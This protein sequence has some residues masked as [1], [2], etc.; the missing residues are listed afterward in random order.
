MS[1]SGWGPGGTTGPSVL[2]VPFHGGVGHP[3][4]GP[5][6]TGWIPRLA[7][8]GLRSPLV[9]PRGARATARGV[10]VVVHSCGETKVSIKTNSEFLIVTPCS[11]TIPKLEH[12]GLLNPKL[13][14]K[15]E[16]KWGSHRGPSISLVKRQYN[17]PVV[18]PFYCTRLNLGISKV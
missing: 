4:G 6:S 10:L 13:I 17:S 15:I 5:F 3:M 8:L 18:K 11:C 7:F 12:R 2:P 16:S 9:S 1:T 14:S